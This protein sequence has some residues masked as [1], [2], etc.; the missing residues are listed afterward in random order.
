[1][2]TFIIYEK[3]RLIAELKDISVKINN[4]QDAV[5]LLGELGQYDC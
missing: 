2:F 3:D 5:D 1:M 4:V